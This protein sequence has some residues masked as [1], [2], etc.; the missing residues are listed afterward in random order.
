MAASA[1]NA[2]TK[3]RVVVFGN[4]VFARNE[5]FDAYAN[6]DVFVNA[7]DWAA[8]ETDLI[9]IT[10]K[11]PVTRT[12]NP[13]GQ[14]PFIMILLGSVIRDPGP[15]P[16]GWR[17]QLA[18]AQEAGLDGSKEH[19]DLMWSCFWRSSAS[20]SSCRGRRAQRAGRLDADERR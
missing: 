9:N 11:T 14:L 1:E 13:P 20:A 6:G 10:P 5:G 12:F 7:V 19:L 4:S 18:G 8:Q 15:D 16:G 3:G 17:L 2:A